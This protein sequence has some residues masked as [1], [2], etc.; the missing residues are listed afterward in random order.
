MKTFEA[1]K[2]R[3]KPGS[4]VYS[5][6]EGRPW[7]SHHTP[8]SVS[9]EWNT[10]TFGKT[11]LVLHSALFCSIK[12]PRCSFSIIVLFRRERKHSSGIQHDVNYVW[13]RVWSMLPTTVHST[14]YDHVASC[15]NME[16]FLQC[17]HSTVVE[18][19]NS[20]KPISELCH[21]GRGTLLVLGKLASCR[22]SEFLLQG[23]AGWTSTGGGALQQ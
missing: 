12:V 19:A 8:H 6:T 21:G 11:I 9:N 7:K 14:K 18:M 10:L 23:R 5:T 16:K 3:E 2:N 13:L 1:S 22:M 4:M 17:R 20:G 15:Y